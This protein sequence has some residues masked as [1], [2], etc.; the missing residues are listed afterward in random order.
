LSEPPSQGESITLSIKV[1]TS[2]VFTYK[3]ISGDNTYDGHCG[4]I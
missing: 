3:Q 2:N 1:S 4:R